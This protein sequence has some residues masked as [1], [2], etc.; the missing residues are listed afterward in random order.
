MRELGGLSYD[1]IGQ[2]LGMTRPSVESTLFR[3]RRRLSEEYESLAT[4]RRCVEVEGIV[5]AAAAAGGAMGARDERKVARHLWNCRSCRHVAVFAGLDVGALA[6]K[7]V[8][9]RIPALL[10]LPAFLRRLLRDRGG[11]ALESP[12]GP[13]PALGA[14]RA[15]GAVAPY[16]DHASGWTKAVAAAVAVAI[17]GLGAGEALPG[18]DRAPRYPGPSLV[19]AAGAAV[20]APGNVRTRPVLLAGTAVP[21]RAAVPAPA[22]AGSPTDPS[23][24]AAV[25]VRAPPRV[26]APAAAVP[27]LPQR[28]PAA[29]PARSGPPAA[30]VPR[31]PQHRPAAAPARPGPPAAASGRS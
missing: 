29:A 12:L 15:A 7:P 8:R 28:R 21:P 10:P 6:K 1:E 27:R 24:G 30:A 19:S 18:A 25:A 16:A 17:A 9:P 26:A 13:L 14:A 4:G 5:T 3:A 22:G 2:R 23:S 31:L 20:S 11:A